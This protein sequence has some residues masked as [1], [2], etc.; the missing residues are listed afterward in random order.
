MRLVT[1]IFLVSSRRYLKYIHIF[2][3]IPTFIF[4]ENNYV[5]IQGKKAFWMITIQ[6]K[7]K[8]TP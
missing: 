2:I 7:S 1:L 3:Y 8:I 4:Y 6:L 5:Y